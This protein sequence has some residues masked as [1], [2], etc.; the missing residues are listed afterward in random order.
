MNGT[1][2]IPKCLEGVDLP[3]EYFRPLKPGE[4]P[5]RDGVNLLELSRYARKAGKKIVDL[6]KEEV[7]QFRS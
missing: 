1:I 6:T 7:D 2:R 4:I 5:P 3:P